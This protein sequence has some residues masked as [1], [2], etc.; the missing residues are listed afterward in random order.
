[1]GTVYPYIIDKSFKTGGVND[2]LSYFI[3]SSTARAAQIMSK[4]NVGDSGN[5]ARLLGLN[6]TDTILNLNRNRFIILL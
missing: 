3:E 5:F 1:M 6:N 4:T 2:P